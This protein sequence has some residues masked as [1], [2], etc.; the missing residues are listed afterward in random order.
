MNGPMRGAKLQ[1]CCGQ[2]QVGISLP[3]AHFHFHFFTGHAKYY[4]LFWSFDYPHSISININI[5]NNIIPF[6]PN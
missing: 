5:K 3:L 4:L 6:S 1:I 2:N